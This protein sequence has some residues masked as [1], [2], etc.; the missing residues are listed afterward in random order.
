[1]TLQE[2]FAPLMDTEFPP[3]YVFVW[4]GGQLRSLYVSDLD[5]HSETYEYLMYNY[6]TSDIFNKTPEG[7]KIPI[8]CKK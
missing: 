5:H 8:L 7:Y 2:L 6:E 1:M 4:V 3:P